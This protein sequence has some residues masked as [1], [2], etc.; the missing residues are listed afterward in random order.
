MTGGVFLRLADVE[1]M[2]VRVLSTMSAAASLGF[3]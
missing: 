3:R 1:A 2:S